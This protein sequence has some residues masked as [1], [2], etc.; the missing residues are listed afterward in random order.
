MIKGAKRKKELEDDT[1]LNRVNRAIEEKKR[2]KTIK[3]R[4]TPSPRTAKKRATMTSHS[5]SNSN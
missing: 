5:K 1:D 2:S 3:D 4:V